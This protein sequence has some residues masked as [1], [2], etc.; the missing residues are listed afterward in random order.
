MLMLNYERNII[1]SIAQKITTLSQNNF[2]GVAIIIVIASIICIN[3][4]IFNPNKTI[5]QTE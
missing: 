3:K 1:I 5:K 2:L 4:R